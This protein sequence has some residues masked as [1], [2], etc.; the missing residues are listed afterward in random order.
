MTKIIDGKALANSI[1]STVKK[2][3]SSL[4]FQPGLTFF[5]IGDSPAS[6]AYVS[7]KKKACARVG[8]KSTVYT[9]EESVKKHTL[10]DA[11]EKENQN[12]NTHAILVQMPLS[13][14]LPP[15][16]ILSHIHPDKDVDG[17][18]PVNMGKTLLGQKGG[19][20]PCTP[21][22]I[23][24]ILETLKLDLGKKEALIIGR[25]NIV[26]KPLA[27]LLMQKTPIAPSSVTVAHSR[28]NDLFSLI[29]KADI[30][31]TA[32]GKPHIISGSILKPGVILIDVG[33]SKVTKGDKTMLLGDVDAK[34]HQ[35]IPAFFTPVP[36]GVGPMT[37][38]MLLQNTLEC[39]YR[40][41]GGES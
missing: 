2:A 27:A 14:H 39:V 31:I 11:I 17:F 29:Q 4:S 22:G 9:M 33:I 34:N 7:M 25:S 37:V 3:I 8:I 41:K 20:L 30:L 10:I 23:C 13:S 19:I 24:H 1:E 38:A 28:T 26:G 40:Q 15:L 21:K 36:G 16:E 32:I 35:H 5:L 18:H 6:K 12:P